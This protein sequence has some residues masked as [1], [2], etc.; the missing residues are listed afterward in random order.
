MPEPDRIF[1]EGDEHILSGIEVTEEGVER[2]LA[3]LKPGK[4][5]GPEHVHPRIL[6]EFSKEL[7]PGLTRL[8]ERSLREGAI[9]GDWESANVVPLH[10]G[11]SK[12]AVG[13]YRPVSLT[14]VICKVL[15]SLLKDAIIA[16]LQRYRLLNKSQHGFISRRS[17]LTNLLTFLEDVTRAVDEGV[18]VDAIYLDF[19]KAFDKVPHQRLLTKLRA[20]GIDG[21]FCSWIEMWL[22]GRKQVVSVNGSSSQQADVISGLPQGSVLGPILF[23]SSSMTWTPGS[24]RSS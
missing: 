17:C 4:A 13:N 3:T 20:H 19:A 12:C 11:G 8:Y 7:A 23:T 15:E 5:P 2:K 22:R 10:K 18:C 21:E 16:H 14:S 6:K 24:S 1:I 9:P